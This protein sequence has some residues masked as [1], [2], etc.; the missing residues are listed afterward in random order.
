MDKLYINNQ[1]IDLGEEVEIYLTYRSNIMGDADSI[2]GNNSATIKV[3]NTEGNAR[4]LE[5]AHI[6]A[7]KTSFPYRVHKA[8]VFRD[9]VHLVR[10][11]TAVLLSANAT[12]FELA[13]A[14]GASEGLLQMAE[15]GDELPALAE[16]WDR[17]EPWFDKGTFSPS[18]RF[19]EAQYGF[20]RTISNGKYWYHPVMTFYEIMYLVKQ[21]Y[22]LNISTSQDIENRMKE[23]AM[24]ISGSATPT[25]E[26][27][28]EF[29]GQ[30][31]TQG[32]LHY[33]VRDFT[34]YFADGGICKYNGVSLSKISLNV[35]AE[36]RFV[37]LLEMDSQT[38]VEDTLR[39]Y[40]CKIKKGET[41]RTIIREIPS[42]SVV[43]KRSENSGHY[44]EVDFALEEED[45]ID[46]FDEG[47]KIQFF[48]GVVPLDWL[49]SLQV[50]FIKTIYPSEAKLYFHR[51][52]INVGDDYY[53]T[54][55]LPKVEILEWLKGMMHLMGLFIYTQGEQIIMRS[56]NEL[57]ERK[58]QAQDWSS[59]LIMSEMGLDDEQDFSLDGYYQVNHLTYE[60]D[61]V[62]KQMN[63][64]FTVDNAT[65]EH[66]GNLIELPFESYAEVD[67]PSKP[68]LAR[69]PF[70]K[71]VNE[72][73]DTWEATTEE[74][75]IDADK[76]YV[77]RIIT[78]SYYLSRE[79]LDWPSLLQNYYA[80]IV[81]SIQQARYITA[82]FYFDT[83]ALQKID[84]GTPVYL[85]QY[86]AYFAI[87]EIKTKKLNIAEVK[88]LKIV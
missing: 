4:A 76:M 84:L 54:R 26:Y 63:G 18:S 25:Q 39:L 3:P 48:A 31:V 35:K 37:S 88:L 1:P 7:T 82:K 28:S 86:A 15:A 49:L 20:V 56:Y 81:Q 17:Y 45:N 47:D 58:A 71:Q 73:D 12:E 10:N 42:S 16:Q 43:F 70:Y 33:A 34:D 40:I 74:D 79:G 51:Q 8:D 52:S 22:A 32:V 5:Y 64:S 36:A 13:L 87:I 55:N 66:E 75:S 2:M 62:N 83:L 80:D 50:E 53:L 41:K 72:N 11:A 38:F 69:F 85:R 59:N 23:L 57:F 19:P 24:V 60:N 44:Y 29:G 61:D 9:G 65:L 21:R 46:T 78:P 30:N 6:V 68:H 67:N 14:W 27:W 77:A